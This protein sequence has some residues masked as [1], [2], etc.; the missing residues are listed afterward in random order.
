MGNLSV[1]ASQR[2]FLPYKKTAFWE[3]NPQSY[4]TTHAGPHPQPNLERPLLAPR[5]LPLN[6]PTMGEASGGPGGGTGEGAGAD[7]RPLG[8]NVLR[9]HRSLVLHSEVLFSTGVFMQVLY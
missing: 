3:Q 4:R 8:A 7:L 2:R 5:R 9:G 1:F 6:W